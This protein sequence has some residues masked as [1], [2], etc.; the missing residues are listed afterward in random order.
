MS[1]FNSNSS[2]AATKIQ[3]SK[4]N[5]LQQSQGKTLFSSN[6]SE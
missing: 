4:E 2:E 1:I 5:S 3:V 6:I